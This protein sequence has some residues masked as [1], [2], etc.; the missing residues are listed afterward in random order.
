MQGLVQLQK[1]RNIQMFNLDSNNN[2]LNLHFP[3]SSVHTEQQHKIIIKTPE[4]IE[5]SPDFPKNDL[6]LEVDRIAK[7]ALNLS[8]RFS[9]VIK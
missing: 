7:R 4:K 9:E 5:L 2:Y 6:P 8:N 1:V 3:F